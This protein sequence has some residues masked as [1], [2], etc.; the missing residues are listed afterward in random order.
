M[1]E[2]IIITPVKNEEK[3]IRKTLE[4]ISLQT[5]RPKRWIIVDDGSNDSTLSIIMEY[6][7]KFDWITLISIDNI[8]AQKQGGTKV[9]RAF[10]K[11]YELIK[12]DK[13]DVICKI[14]GDLLFPNNYFERIM[15][16]YN[17]NENMGVCGGICVIEE[18]NKLIPEKYNLNSLRGPIKSY[19]KSCFD[20]IGGIMHTFNWDT[21]DNIMALYYNWEILIIPELKVIHL[22]PTS[23]DINNGLK[24]YYSDG[25]EDNKIGYNFLVIFI[26]VCFLTVRK[27]FIIGAFIY[28]FGFTRGKLRKDKKIFQK[29]LRKF[30]SKYKHNHFIK[31][32]KKRAHSIIR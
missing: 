5:Y 32:I 13:F 4:S 10:Y 24:F 6:D 20:E 21:I 3:Y 12:E 11:G 27:P 16:E 28:L 9:V 14:D 8:S 15:L 30:A 17:N 1:M 18:D 23:T 31:E 29:E 25:I 2:Y 26:K 19:R 7:K 22:K